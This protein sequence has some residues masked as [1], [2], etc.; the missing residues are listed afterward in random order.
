MRYAEIDNR[1]L[2]PWRPITLSGID[3]E[4]TREYLRG[5]SYVCLYYDAQSLFLSGKWRC[6]LG[7]GSSEHRYYVACNTLEE[8]IA[9]LD[10]LLIEDGFKLLNTEEEAAKYRCLI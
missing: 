1:I 2:L 3:V 8:A 4:Y 5:G 7:N 6:V 9:A 10:K